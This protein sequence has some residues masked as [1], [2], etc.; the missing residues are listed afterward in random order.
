MV[1]AVLTGVAYCEYSLPGDTISDGDAEVLVV[2]ADAGISCERR[3]EY[4]GGGDATGSAGNVSVLIPNAPS[5]WN[6]HRQGLA[7]GFPMLLFVMFAWAGWVR[8]PERNDS[9]SSIVADCMVH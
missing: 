5:R 6:S 4:G 1:V 2:L 3:G 9:N 7:A 8:L